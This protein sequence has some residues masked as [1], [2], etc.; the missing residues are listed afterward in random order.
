MI[1]PD[2]L[3]HPIRQRLSKTIICL[4]SWYDEKRYARQNWESVVEFDPQPLFIRMSGVLDPYKRIQS[5]LSMRDMWPNENGMCA[6]G[7]GKPAKQ[8]WHEPSHS[9]VAYQIFEIIYGKAGTIEKYIRMLWPVEC[10]NCG[11]GK[12]EEVTFELDHLIPVKHGGGAS[13]LSN[14]RLRCK[15]CHRKK[16]NEDFGWKKPKPIPLFVQ[17]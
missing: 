3:S 6:C 11:I 16:T 4:P 1:S 8:R 9:T 15:K 7:C 13:W 5:G 10:M 12:G 17:A 2:E 14:Y